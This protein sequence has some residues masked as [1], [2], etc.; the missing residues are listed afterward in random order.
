M[1]KRIGFGVLILSFISSYVWLLTI[2]TL[3]KC[4]RVFCKEFVNA[5]AVQWENLAE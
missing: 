3:G 2:R 5:E 1:K 4:K